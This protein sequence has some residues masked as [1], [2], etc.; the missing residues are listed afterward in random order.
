MDALYLQLQEN[1]REVNRVT[2]SLTNA[3]QKQLCPMLDKVTTQMT[4]TASQLQHGMVMKEIQ[5]VVL[6]VKNVYDF[7]KAFQMQCNA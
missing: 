5:R 1:I 6:A 3:I 7:S 2:Q 4:G